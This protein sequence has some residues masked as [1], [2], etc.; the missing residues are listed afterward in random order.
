MAFRKPEHYQL[1]SVRTAYEAQVLL[2]KNR[3]FFLEMYK[4]ASGLTPCPQLRW[5]ICGLWE[6]EL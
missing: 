6:Q 1:N 4:Y 3:Q 2:N 5:N